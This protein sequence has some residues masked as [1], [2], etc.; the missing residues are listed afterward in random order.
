M[1][2]GLTI[3]LFYLVDIIQFFMQLCVNYLNKCLVAYTQEGRVLTCIV[4]ILCHAYT[5][6]LKY[7]VF[8]KLAR[9]SIK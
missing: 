1:I 9:K 2:K 6:F 8:D 3:C 4:R 5:Y 7:Q